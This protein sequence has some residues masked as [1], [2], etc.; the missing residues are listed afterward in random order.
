MEV[1]GAEGNKAYQ[2]LG[3]QT[4]LIRIN[5]FSVLVVPWDLLTIINYPLTEKT[6]M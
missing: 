6:W 5:S 2:A 4:T 1:R 3:T